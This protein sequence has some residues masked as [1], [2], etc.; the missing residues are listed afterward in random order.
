MP[1]K[2]TRKPGKNP[3]THVQLRVLLAFALMTGVILTGLILL[4][5]SP[6]NNH[7]KSISDGSDSI[8]TQEE[9]SYNIRSVKRPDSRPS[10]KEISVLNPPILPG[11]QKALKA[12]SAIIMD[13]LGANTATTR[14]VAKLE[15][16][17]TMAII[18]D[19]I[20]ARESMNIAAKCD[21]EVM[22]H[23]P[24]EPLGYP[25][26]NPGEMALML[27]M[28]R[29]EVTSRTLYYLRRLPLAKGCNNHMGSAFTQDAPRMEAV[30]EQL[31]ARGMF[32]VDSLTSSKSVGAQI[33]R[34]LGVTN[35]RRDV[36]L[37]NERDVEKITQQLVKLLRIA[38][39][40]GTS[41]GICHPYPETITALN[42][43][44]AL[45]AEYGVDIVP[46]SKLVR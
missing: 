35:A 14:Q 32:F 4:T 24:M 31:S 8:D 36:F 10:D 34:N 17:I 39:K 13:D 43:C 29:D 2:K 16:P 40:N 19:L 30:L 9:E 21:R 18:P 20:H 11:K 25:E 12:Y 45:A 6:D 37:D 15:V 28:S 26:Q 27:D 38:E 44:A 41:L 1:S 23:L 46:V 33:A 7:P 42:N 5:Y 22:V 3:R